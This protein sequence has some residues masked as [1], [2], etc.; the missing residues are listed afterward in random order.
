MVRFLRLE[1]TKETFTRRMM[2][3]FIC[4]KNNL[5]FE[6]ALKT[7]QK[8][9]SRAP[10]RNNNIIPLVKVSLG[11]YLDSF[12]SLVVLLVEKLLT[13]LFFQKQIFKHN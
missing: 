12:T 8:V 2:F 3:W 13:Y 6:F 5:I 7:E 11:T 9:Q 1:L 4:S 10:Q